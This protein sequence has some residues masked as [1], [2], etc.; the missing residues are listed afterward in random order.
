MFAVSMG[1]YEIASNVEQ[2]KDMLI[3]QIQA[4]ESAPAG[5]SLEEQDETHLQYVLSHPSEVAKVMWDRY[6]TIIKIDIPVAVNGFRYQFE[7]RYIW[8]LVVILLLSKKVLTYKE[9]IYSILVFCMIWFSIIVVGYTWQAP[10]YGSIWGISPR[11]M[12]PM[13][14]LL[15]TVLCF[16]ND[17]T[18]RVVNMTAPALIL[19][20]AV[21]NIISMIIVYY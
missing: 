20:A 21:E 11:Y 15:F 4:E 13:L 2:I 12:I 19:G 9:K 18:D 7:N 1:S 16:G 14:P 8:L 10:D 5:D 6:K 17:K 3:N